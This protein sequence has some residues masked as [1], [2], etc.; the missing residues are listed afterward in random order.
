M[1]W[2]A[3]GAIGEILG[4]AGVI[5]TLAYLAVQIR[6]NSHQI[7]RSVQAT[8]ISADDAIARGFDQWRQLL[9]SDEK[10]SDIFVRGLQD[11]SALD[12]N[13]RHRFNQ[14]LNTFVWAGWQMWRSRDVMGATNSEFFRHLLRH[15]GA[16]DWYV[17]SRAYFPDEYREML[18]GVLKDLQAEG[19]GFFM[20]HDSSSMLGGALRSDV[21]HEPGEQS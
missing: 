21:G 12:T 8:R 3:I 10:V 14:L 11:I 2:E 15:P 16:R 17:G 18:D 19:A 9:I 6:Q 20:P 4:A 7:E 5:I 13:E 1:N